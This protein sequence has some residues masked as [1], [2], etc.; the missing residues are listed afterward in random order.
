MSLFAAASAACGIAPGLGTLVAARFAQGAAAAVMM[1]ASTALIGHAY[2]DA[3]RRARAVAIWA[4][5]AGQ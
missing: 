5:V 3:R 2:P 1:S 4:I